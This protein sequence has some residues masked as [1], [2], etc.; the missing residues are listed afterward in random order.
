MLSPRVPRD[1]GA[2]SL[3][4]LV[5][6]A[7]AVTISLWATS[8]VAVAG[9]GTLMIRSESTV[10]PLPGATLS[11]AVRLDA[12]DPV[13]TVVPTV[14]T[15]PS[16][17]GLSIPAPAVAPVNLSRCRTDLPDRLMTI[18]MA[19][20]SYTCPVYDGGQV[21]LNSGAVVLI[22]VAAISSALADH[23]GDAGTLWIAGHR[24]SHG[25]AF[26]AVPDLADGA[27]VTVADGTSTASYRVIGRIH[28]G[29]SNDR[30]IDA[31]GRATAAATLDS[32]LRPDH[33]GGNGAA[34]LLLQT[35]DGDNFRWMIYADLVTD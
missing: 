30:V 14:P 24:T 29:I 6:T 33:G 28:V 7:L 23:P 5:G 22:S 20:I 31:S 17:A 34:R 13:D 4:V 8:G 21:A 12:P 32:V 11:P 26:A 19:D 27:I 2:T 15:A 9:S 35:C 3:F 1:R 25:A 16:D 10:G 18:T